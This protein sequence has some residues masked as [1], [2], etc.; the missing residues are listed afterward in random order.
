M[1]LPWTIDRRDHIRQW[2]KGESVNNV[3]T[4][5]ST[6]PTPTPARRRGSPGRSLFPPSA[7]LC[8][9][10]NFPTECA[11][12]T[13]FG[14][15]CDHI[16]LS[17]GILKVEFLLQAF[18]LATS[19]LLAALEARLQI[20]NRILSCNDIQGTG[21]PTLVLENLIL[22]ENLKSINLPSAWPWL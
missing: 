10:C 1:S 4:V 20:E 3:C 6:F 5:I 9:R 22:S 19:D 12:P 11:S 16:C 8:C 18:V 2:E 13:R 7:M 21:C 15:L 14:P 17:R